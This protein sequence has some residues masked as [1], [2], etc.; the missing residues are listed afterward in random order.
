MR[1]S[2]DAAAALPAVDDLGVFEVGVFVSCAFAEEQDVLVLGSRV[3]V[4]VDHRV[5]HEIDASTPTG[6]LFTI[7]IE[8]KRSSVSRRARHGVS[9][10]VVMACNTRWSAPWA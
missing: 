8:T 10:S 1:P 2:V 4:V 6:A 3:E 7:Y 5:P 9:S